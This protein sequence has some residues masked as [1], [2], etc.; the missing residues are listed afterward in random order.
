MSNKLGQRPEVKWVVAALPD[1]SWMSGW[2]QLSS[3][4]DNTMRYI[5]PIWNSVDVL[6][7]KSTL[8][9]ASFPDAVISHSNSASVATYRGQVISRL[10]RG[11]RDYKQTT[12]RRDGESETEELDSVRQSTCIG[13]DS[14]SVTPS[15]SCTRADS[16]YCMSG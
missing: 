3:D 11:S 16:V 10:C 13:R 4:A 12:M 15:T 14:S 2:P 9:M 7:L 5:P 6:S 1:S 8:I